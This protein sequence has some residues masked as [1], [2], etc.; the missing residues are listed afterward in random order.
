MRKLR[1]LAVVIPALVLPIAFAS[2]A[3][4]NVPQ[5]CSRAQISVGII[6]DN[7][8]TYVH[9]TYDTLLGPTNCTGPGWPVTWNTVAGFWVGNSSYRWCLYDPQRQFAIGGGVGPTQV[10]LSSTLTQSTW[11]FLVKP[12]NTGGCPNAV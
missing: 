10:W 12:S 6:H 1:L 11:W 2:P 5:L 9:G 7:D 8:G 3:S 4:A